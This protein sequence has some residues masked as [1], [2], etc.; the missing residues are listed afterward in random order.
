MHGNFSR[1]MRFPGSEEKAFPE[2]EANAR[3]NLALEYIVAGELEA[4][5]RVGR[6]VN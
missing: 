5:A 1:N 4:A 3:I 6:P 2:G